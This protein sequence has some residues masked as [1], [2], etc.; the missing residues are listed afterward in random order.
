MRHGYFGVVCGLVMGLA[1]GVGSAQAS[2]I[3]WGNN[4]TFGNVTLEAFDMDT[5]ALVDQF[6][7][8]NINARNDNGRGIAVVGTT[9]YYTTA[10][11]GDIFI[12]DSVTHAD[13][14]TISILNPDALGGPAPFNGLASIAWDGSALWVI[15]YNGT[16]N[17]Y[18]YATDGTLL[19]TVTGFGNNRD[20]FEIA[21]NHIIANNGDAQGPYDLYD[22]NGVLVQANFINP[23]FAPTGIT[24]DGTNYYVSNIYNNQIAI[25][26]GTGAFVD[27]KTLGGPVPQPGYGRLLEDLSS[28]GNIPTSPPGDQ[29]GSGACDDGVDGSWRIGGRVGQ[30]QASD[31]SQQNHR[32]Q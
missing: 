6:L 1:V 13:L 3:G 18:R 4:A 16:N 14:G 7:A 23:P 24:F 31:L 19:Q 28:L 2:T 5:G 17:A 9:I 25:Y 8:P 26:D 21:N 15:G 32:K 11:L 20:G 10:N 12:T 30:P 29:H 27:A 22:L